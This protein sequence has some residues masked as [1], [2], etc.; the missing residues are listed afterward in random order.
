MPPPRTARQHRA[1]RAGPVAPFFGHL[2]PGYAANSTSRGG[3]EVPRVPSV[4]DKR[5]GLD[6]L[7]ARGV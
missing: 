1:S 2:Q 4:R 7:E 6:R 3:F 5:A